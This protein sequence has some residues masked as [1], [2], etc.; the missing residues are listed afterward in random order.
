MC[1]MKRDG[2][3]VDN[4]LQHSGSQAIHFLF[5]S[6]SLFVW[7]YSILEEPTWEL[8][9]YEGFGMLERGQLAKNGMLSL[10]TLEGNAIMCDLVYRWEAFV[11]ALS[12]LF[13]ILILNAADPSI[14][15]C[16]FNWFFIFLCPFFNFL[17]VLHP[18][19]WLFYGKGFAYTP[20]QDHCFSLFPREGGTWSGKLCLL[21][22]MD[23]FG[24]LVVLLFGEVPC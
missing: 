24:K 7:I 15:V 12:F 19:N 20:V 4:I 18:Y 5:F 14:F 2:E 3:S 16:R 23:F 11:G 1:C 21:F 9:C 8:I 17:N 13:T 10:W 22:D 6:S